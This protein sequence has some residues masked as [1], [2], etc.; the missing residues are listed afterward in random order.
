MGAVYDTLFSWTENI[1]TQP[2]MVE[3]YPVSDNKLK[4]TMTLRPGLKFHDGS[5]VPS[6]DVV[7]SLKRMVAREVLGRSIEPF[8]AS[9]ETIDDKTFV[10]NLKEPV[11]LLLFTIG[12]SANP[13]G[14][15]R[16]Q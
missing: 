4:Y 14:S 13:E 10:I 12:G 2:Q 3:R 8:L 15:C 11:G 6:K 1:E 7:A 16:P 5:P 9:L